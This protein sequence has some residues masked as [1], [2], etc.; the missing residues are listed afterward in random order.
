MK[1]SYCLID[2]PFKYNVSYLNGNLDYNP[3][4]N[5]LITLFDTLA[6]AASKSTWELRLSFP[7]NDGGTCGFNY[8]LKVAN[9]FD[10]IVINNKLYII[11]VK[12]L[13]ST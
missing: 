3:P 12:Q 4:D 2:L 1:I 6:Q 8:T 10:N 13:C 9:I 5:K 7:I 11:S